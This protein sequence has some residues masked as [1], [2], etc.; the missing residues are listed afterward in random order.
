[1]PLGTRSLSS[2]RGAILA[3]VPRTACSDATPVGDMNIF[4]SWYG[5]YSRLL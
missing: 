4:N 5:E 2:A 1:M 3:M